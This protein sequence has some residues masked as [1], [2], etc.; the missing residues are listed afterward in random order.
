MHGHKLFGDGTEHAGEFSRRGLRIAGHDEYPLPTKRV[1][2][3]TN[4]VVGDVVKSGAG[5]L[6]RGDATE[7]CVELRA[8]MEGQTVCAR[9]GDAGMSDREIIPGAP[10]ISERGNTPGKP[11]VRQRCGSGSIGDEGCLVEEGVDMIVGVILHA[12]SVITAGTDEDEGCRF[13]EIGDSEGD[14]AAGMLTIHR[15][16]QASARLNP[17]VNFILAQL[18]I[19][20]GAEEH[21][22]NAA[23]FGDAVFDG[24]AEGAEGLT[25]ARFERPDVGSADIGA[26]LQDVTQVCGAAVA[27][28]ASRPPIP[29]RH[30]GNVGERHGASLYTA[31]D[32]IEDKMDGI[33]RVTCITDAGEIYRQES[34]AA[35]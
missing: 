24:G 27:C 21:K 2:R 18:A 31:G 15:K 25:I 1:Y 13:A 10:D 30:G 17:S 3:A 23:E 8:T 35:F 16:D 29:H 28:G 22:I 14:G 33:G 32:L 19:R 11:D 4:G 20:A 26:S 12:V 7:C 9:F 5:I 34:Q 6:I